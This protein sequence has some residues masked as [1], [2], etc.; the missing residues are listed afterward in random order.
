MSALPM[1]SLPLVR[2]AAVLLGTWI[3]SRRLPHRPRFALRTAVAASTLVILV[4]TVDWLGFV[5]F[6]HI[7]RSH[8]LA[9]G[10]ATRTGLLACLV[11]AVLA[12]FETGVWGALFRAALGLTL[13]GIAEGMTMVIAAV[14][15]LVPETTPM[16]FEAL[17]LAACAGIACLL[18]SITYARA[19]DRSGAGEFADNKLLPVF[20]IAVLVAIAFGQV[21]QTLSRSSL[22]RGMVATL[23]LIRICMCAFVL[24]SA[25]EALYN[26]RLKADMAA[27]E[28]LMHSKES[29]YALSRETIDAINVKC[30][31]IRHQ[32]RELAHEGAVVD[33]E[34]LD[35]IASEVRV[36]DTRVSTG[37]D[38]LD[39]I[40]TEKSLI[41]ERESIT[42]TCIADGS[43]LGFLKPSEIYS[44]FGNALDNAIEASRCVDDL[45]LR[46]I[47][48]SVREALGMVSIHVEN[49]FA[50]E[51]RFLD[52]MPLTSKED[53]ANHGF[54]TKS[55]AMVVE[56]HDGT[57]TM[58]AQ[59]DLFCLDATIPIP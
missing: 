23:E 39:T 1:F 36:Y 59:R 48:L 22:D 57:L 54:G 38:A 51:V 7:T 6:D 43:A 29:Q 15:G 3:F 14:L 10:L 33:R 11:A 50:G 46:T 34:V 18:V 55:M 30:H 8:F 21:T 26:A 56:R 35:D 16:A 32:I 17:L 37:N 12:C 4:L 27:T 45:A 5:R 49:R 47:S 24:F 19:I 2:V 44:L 41:C 42:F 58:E 31:D 40:L 52:G 53:R 20:A 25:F 13:E 28:A 9:W